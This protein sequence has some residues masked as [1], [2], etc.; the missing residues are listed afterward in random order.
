MTNQAEL[1]AASITENGFRLTAARLI[2]IDCLVMSGG[3][4]S[5][6]ELVAQV[7]AKSPTVGRMTVFRTLEL[8]T[9]LG[10]IQPTYLGTG[11]AH[12]VLMQGGSHHHLICTRCQR[13]I[14]FDD[15][16]EQE[17][18]QMLGE[19]YQFIVQSHLLEVHGI[20]SNCRD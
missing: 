1:L 8:L 9:E 15:C 7:H 11:A 10:Q 12:Y 17:L 16:L 13:V 19:K 6:D 20:C 4:I 5:A 14:D 2:V 3:H 18:A